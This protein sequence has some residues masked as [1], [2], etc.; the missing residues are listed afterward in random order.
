MLAMT[1]LLASQLVSASDRNLPVEIQK[2]N[3]CGW[4]SADYQRACLDSLRSGKSF[5]FL[6]DTSKQ[7]AEEYRVFP[8]NPMKPETVSNS[9]SARI[10]DSLENIDWS[11]RIIAGVSLAWSAVSVIMLLKD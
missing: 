1:A 6:K 7:A 8:G 5:I 4:I 9:K 11:L 3:Q 2:K 10:E